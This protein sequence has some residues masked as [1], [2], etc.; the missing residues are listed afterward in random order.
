MSNNS[1]DLALT[2][3]FL[4]NSG[5]QSCSRLHGNT[6][7]H[8]A[9]KLRDPCTHTLT[10]TNTLGSINSNMGMQPHAKLHTHAPHASQDD[11]LLLRSFQS[12]VGSMLFY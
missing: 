11:T 7:G 5:L 9:Y 12:L 4:C 6:Y 8:C 2:T 1:R 10:F 3:I